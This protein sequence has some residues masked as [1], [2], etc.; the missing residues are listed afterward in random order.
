MENK[1]GLDILLIKQDIVVTYMPYMLE[2]HITYSLC[3]FFEYLKR[4]PGA[5]MSAIAVD[6][7]IGNARATRAIQAMDA[8]GYVNVVVD[9]LDT[10]SKLVTL[11]DKGM[12]VSNDLSRFLE[13]YSESTLNN[14]LTVDEKNELLRL[15]DKIVQTK[16][17]HFKQFE[18]FYPK[19]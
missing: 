6:L 15:L 18:Q 3:T 19:L 16:K 17:S 1:F 13:E 5:R 7:H 10:R 4:N 14:S 12:Q 11:S 8:E 9:K 2:H